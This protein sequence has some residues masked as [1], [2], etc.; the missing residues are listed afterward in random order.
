MEVLIILRDECDK[1]LSFNARANIIQI[2]V[3][4]VY[5]QN[6]MAPIALIGKENKNLVLTK[7]T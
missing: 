4:Y 6:S 5:N 7:N 1:V 2:I 3:V